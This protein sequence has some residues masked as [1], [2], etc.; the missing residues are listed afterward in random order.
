MNSRLYWELL[1]YGTFVEDEGGFYAG[2]IYN[3]DDLKTYAIIVSISDQCVS[4]SI[5]WI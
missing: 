3:P 5:R 1:D 2:K 4:I